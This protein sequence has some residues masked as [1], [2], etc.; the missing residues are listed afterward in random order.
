MNENG[1]DLAAVSRVSR[2]I[3]LQ[4][5]RVIQL[6]ASCSPAPEGPLEPQI[7][8]DCKGVLVTPDQLNI[9]CD[10]TFNANT[11][12]ASAASVQVIYLLVYEVSGDPPTERDVEQ[13]A[14]VNGV[15]HSWPFLRQLL[16]DLT[17]KMGLPPLTLPVFQVLPRTQAEKA[18]KPSAL[19]K[20]KPRRQK[21]VSG[22]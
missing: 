13:F 2:N 12:G 10:Y 20:S 6:V 16:F 15:Y 3:D 1:V 9:A 7:T 8:F 22:Q 21:A 17:A 19:E 14:R 5:L 4:D 18:E 11:A